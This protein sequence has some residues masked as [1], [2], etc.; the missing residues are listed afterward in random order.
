MLGVD[1][2]RLLQGQTLEVLIDEPP[3]AAG[4]GDGPRPP[5]KP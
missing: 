1:I 4:D 2:G 5:S 3:P